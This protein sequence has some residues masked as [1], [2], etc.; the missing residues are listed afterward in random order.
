MIKKR[1]ISMLVLLLMAVT[2][3]MA[4]PITVTWTSSNGSFDYRVQYSGDGPYYDEDIQEWVILDD[5]T[6][7]TNLGNFTQI[8]ISGG[9]VANYGADGWND[10]TWTGNASSVYMNA[11]VTSA[12]GN[13]NFTITF[14][15]EPP[16]VAV[17]GITLD[18][19]SAE[20]TVGGETLTLT[21]TVA[22]DDAADKTVTWTSSDETVATVTDG[23]VTAVAAGTA[24][25]TVTTTD[26]AKTATCTVTVAEP[27]YT[28]SVKEGTEDAAN[29]TITPAE[30]TTPGVAAG[31]EV[32]ATYG[33]TKRVKSVKA[34]KKAN[35]V[36]LSTLE[37]DYVAQNGDVLTGTLEGSERPYKISIAD[38]ATVT[39][40][41][42]TLNGICGS[43]FNPMMGETVREL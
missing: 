9:Y 37:G 20:M 33:G 25:I 34:K 17:T 30:A 5:G 29:W 22:P 32:K 40:D 31:T 8:Q 16:T 38:G 1:F 27:T 12:Y 42:A 7:T 23:V 4:E 15:I 6:F 24:T 35:I 28:V 3:A 21:A 26:G 13:D 36:N 14:T 19:T 2:G 43:G 18:K 41:N 39:L 10:R 11:Y